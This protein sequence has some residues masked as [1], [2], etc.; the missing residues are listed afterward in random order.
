MSMKRILVLGAGRSSSSLIRYIL[1]N[2]RAFQWHLTVG[3]LSIKSAQE[4]AGSFEGCEA[5]QFD[6]NDT[7]VSKA[8]ISEA[9]IV[10]SLLPASFHPLVA[11][12]CL[13]AGKDRKSVV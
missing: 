3:D 7:D 10:I 9:D 6:I 13:E 11:F 4:K 2:A 1:E 8:T 12:R 5:V